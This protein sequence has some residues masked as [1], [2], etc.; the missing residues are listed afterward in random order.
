MCGPSFVLG[1]IRLAADDEIQRQR[2]LCVHCAAAWIGTPFFHD[3]AVKSAGCDCSHLGMAYSEALQVKITWPTKY[4]VNPQWFMHADPASGE[5]KEIYLEGLLD[6][7][8]VE[9][10]DGQPNFQPFR[11]DAW[12]DAK[13]DVGDVV[14][15]RLGRL[16]AHGAIIE[17]WPNVIQAEPYI[18]GRGKVVRAT[19]QANYFLNHRPL[20]FFSWKGWH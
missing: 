13:K 5:F 15:A 2:H 11:A 18:C 3:G 12:I 7:G 1:H 10:S 14:I 4:I 6:N 19:A 16:F 8:F 20:R 17:Y 9:L